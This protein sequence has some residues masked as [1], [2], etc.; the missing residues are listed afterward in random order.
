MYR[1][2]SQRLPLNLWLI[3]GLFLV[4]Q[5]LSGCASIL[6]ASSGPEQI[7][8]DPGTRTFG[9]YIEDESIETKT[10]ANLYNADAVSYTHLTLPT[11]SR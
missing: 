11:N 6:S 10:L 8:E 4:S 7:D 3:C 5:C 9:S 2:P 1:T